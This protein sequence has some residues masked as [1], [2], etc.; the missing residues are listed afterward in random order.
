MRILYEDI[1]R[2]F[3]DT[4]SDWHHWVNKIQK[5][6]DRQVWS[7]IK[8][9]KPYAETTGQIPL[10]NHTATQIQYKLKLFADFFKAEYSISQMKKL[11]SELTNS[12]IRWT[13]G[14]ISDLHPLNLLPIENF[15]ISSEKL[16]KAPGPDG[17]HNNVLK[18]LSK[19]TLVRLTYFFNAAI[20]A[21]L[22]PKV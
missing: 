20:K 22:F 3:T 13:I 10:L 19:K 11:G 4:V 21:Q 14:F 15:W 8:N 6:K 7:F 5:F 2:R 18:N 12:I 1:M 9:R 17:I 16:Y